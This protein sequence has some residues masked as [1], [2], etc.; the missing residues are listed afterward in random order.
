MMKRL[1][2]LVI[3]L[4]FFFSCEKEEENSDVN[5]NNSNMGYNCTIEGCYA[6]ENAQ[7]ISLADCESSCNNNN[8]CTNPE[9]SNYNP[10]AT[11][12][13]GSCIILGC[14]DEN[15]TNYNPEA[16]NDNGSCEYT[17]SF[18]LNGNWDIISLEYETEIDL[19]N[20]PT[21]GTFLG[22]QEISGE[23]SNAGTWIFEYP[24]YLYSNNL[25][26]TTE[27][28][29]VAGFDIPG[30][31]IDVSSNGDWEIT[32][33]DYILLAT[34]ANTSLESIYEILSIQNNDAF[35][36]GTIPF[37]QEIMGFSFNLDID[38]KMQLQKQ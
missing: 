3:P 34:D 11:E 27:P 32:N 16:T 31:P 29:N 20:I 8:G 2:L 9:A 7:Y 22:T 19:S 13:D 23:V 21:V 15:A 17:V 36:N 26:F 35:I 12:D 28:I 30:F 1:L 25:N 33:N 24:E 37:E 6:A 5:N 18:L 4:I 14:T 10:N 38:V